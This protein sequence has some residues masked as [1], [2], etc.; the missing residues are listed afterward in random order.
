M[1]IFPGNWFLMYLNYLIY[2][3]FVTCYYRDIYIFWRKLHQISHQVWLQFIGFC[4]FLIDLMSLALIPSLFQCCL[5]DCMTFIII[6]NSV[7]RV[8]DL[9]SDL[10]LNLSSATDLSYGTYQITWS[11]WTHFLIQKWGKEL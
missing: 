7:L 10:S 6:K 9:Q 4:F 3:I 2:V 1:L 5:W 11:L 8:Q